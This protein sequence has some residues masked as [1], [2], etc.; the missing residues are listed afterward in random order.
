MSD[1]GHTVTTIPAG[2]NLDSLVANTNLRF[3][4]VGGKGGVGKTTSSAAIATQLSFNRRGKLH[5]YAFGWKLHYFEY[6]SITI[7]FIFIVV[8]LV[9]TDPAHSL[10]D[11]FRCQFGAEP[12]SPNENALPNLDVMELDPTVTV[13]VLTTLRSH[14]LVNLLKGLNPFCGDALCIH[15]KYLFI[16]YYNNRPN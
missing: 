14:I 15:C 12:I 1:N 6:K 2:N 7:F 8:L 9:S 4:F 13:E 16:Y 11:A 5:C 10:S 3:I